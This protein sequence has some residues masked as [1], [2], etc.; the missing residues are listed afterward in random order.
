MLIIL[1]ISN[2]NFIFALNR[3]IMNILNKNNTIRFGSFR[4]LDTDK[5]YTIISTVITHGP[6]E[7]QYLDKCI[8]SKDTLKREDG[9]KRIF[10][11]TQLKKRFKNVEQVLIKQ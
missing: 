8:K 4:C 5:V 9:L 10:T 6:K 7:V 3:L 11:R 1:C 2:I